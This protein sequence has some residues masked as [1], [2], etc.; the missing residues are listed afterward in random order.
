MSI[1]TV[2]HDGSVSSLSFSGMPRLSD[3]LTEYG[4]G[5]HSPCG[6]RGVCGKCAV[7][8]SGRISAPD[9][10]ETAAGTRLACRVR[11]QGN[12]TVH[13]PFQPKTE[14]LGIQA[15]VS[16]PEAGAFNIP[17]D[18][19]GVADIGTT[20]IAA[21]FFD[22]E[23]GKLIST[24]S[25]DNPQCSVSADVIGRISAALNGQGKRLQNMITFCLKSMA[26]QSGFDASLRRWILTGNTTMLTL[27]A[28]F[29][30]LALS[31]APFKAAYLFDQQMEIDGTPAYFPP[32]AHAFIGADALCA[33]LFSG[34]YQKKT[35]TCLL[36]DVGT[37]GEILL[38]K[39]SICYA[40]SAAAG[41]ALEGAGIRY[42]CRGIPGAI[43][44][45]A[46]M[47]GRW[48]ANT[49]GGGKAVGICGSGLLDAV[50]CGLETGVISPEGFMEEPLCLRDGIVLLPEDIRQV[51]LAKAALR[52]GIEMLLQKTDTKAEEIHQLIL[53]GGFG[54]KLNPISAARIG[55][56][57]FELL[58]RTKEIGNAA[59]SGAA[60]LMQEENKEKLRQLRNSLIYFSLGGDPEFDRL[61]LNRISFP[62]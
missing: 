3:V 33:L 16:E 35:E 37:N 1:L 21:A 4:L 43:D 60:M 40:A 59:L 45:V 15:G 7:E 49:I 61:Y 44:R 30:P 41:P 19:I 38:W 23:N 50:A 22:A 34:I 13:L 11:L 14:A 54:S 52:A 46:V 8:I 18:V 20:T 17:T 56:I 55:M 27:L 26:A 32:C 47:G 53:C 48:I 6:G 31:R 51:Q 39:N 58:P 12:A 5:I 42:G 57:P 36:C 9:D 62:R 10:R 2:F 24:Q 29:S 28:G 25:A